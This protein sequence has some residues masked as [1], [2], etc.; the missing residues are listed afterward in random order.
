M[1]KAALV[2]VVVLWALAVADA[3]A[4]QSVQIIQTG[5]V[6]EGAAMQVPMPGREL[7]T[8]TGRIRG[9]VLAADNGAPLRRA[10]VRISGTEIM[11]KTAMTDAQGRYEFRDLPA[12]RFN[13]S[14]TKS[15]FVTVQ[16]GQTRPFESGKTIELAEA[17][18]LDKADVSIPR[19][20]VISGRITDEFGDPLPDVNVVAMRSTW[21]GG[22]RRLQP[23]GRNAQTNDLG[24]YRIFGLPPGE[25]YVNAT[26]RSG[27]NVLIET[28]AE[29]AT[30]AGA[31]GPSASNPNSGYAPT[32]FPG[33]PSGAEAQKISLALGQEAQQIDFALMPVRLA[34]VTGMVIDS[35]GKP[36]SGAMINTMPRSGDRLEMMFSLGGSAR[37]DKNGNFTLNGVAPGDYILQTRQVMT[38]TS[39][40][41]AGEMVFAA[42]VGGPGGEG[43][44][45]G[46]LPI[47]VA[48]ED[49]SGVVIVT[50]KGVTATGRLVFEGGQ[51]PQNTPMLRVAAPIADPSP[52]LG[53]STA[54]VQE[55]G[56]FE[57]KGLT[58]LRLVRAIG[59]PPG[60]TLKS[61][62]LNG[63]DVTDTGVEFKGSEPVSGLEV[64][65][66]PKVTAIAGGVTTSSGE[67][68]T[69]YTV[70]IFSDDPDHWTMPQTRWVTG[71]RP[72][73]QGRFEAKGLPPGGYYAIAVDYIPQGEWGDPELLEKLKTKATR[74][75]LDEGESKRL[76]LKLA[77]M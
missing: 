66:T 12:S 75:S 16:Y 33:T 57:L 38:M 58:G 41:G 64:V 9:R 63:D 60:W 28:M 27:E 49:I 23:A 24:Q 44:E 76:D 13:I 50:T 5:P 31:S 15:G 4:Q 30:A 19:G 1:R 32:Y 73:T 47:T 70:V 35:Q 42:R 69:D 36:V 61:V 20:S 53:G 3:S 17:Q 71:T 6:G 37:T 56:S 2:V 39:M 14:V 46:M 11:P 74:F 8:G 43:A 52:G 40:G 45:A 72:N 25:Y 51:R 26:L 22:R 67:A 68:V 18:V 21:S 59:L 34:K 55:D 54:Q 77:T 7:K 62:R 10:Q 48:G 29:S 65:V